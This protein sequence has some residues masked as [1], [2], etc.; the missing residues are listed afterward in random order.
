MIKLAQKYSCSSYGQNRFT[1]ETSND[2]VFAVVSYLNSHPVTVTVSLGSRL[3]ISNWQLPYRLY[4][5][6]PLGIVAVKPY[7]SWS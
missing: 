7:R 2:V 1:Q 5:V 4:D 6:V 3:P